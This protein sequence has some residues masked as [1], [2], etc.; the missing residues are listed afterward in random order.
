[1]ATLAMGRLRHFF[2]TFGFAA[3]AV[4]VLGLSACAGD[5]GRV[6]VDLDGHTWA[7]M[8][9][10]LGDSFEVTGRR[11]DFVMVDDPTVRSFRLDPSNPVTPSALEVLIS[12]AP[13]VAPLPDEQTVE[14]T[15]VS[16]HDGLV[17]EDWRPVDSRILL[18]PEDWIEFAESASARNSADSLFEATDHA[19][20]DLPWISESG[21]GGYL[22]RGSSQ[23]SRGTIA[24]PETPPDAPT[25][26]IQVYTR[27]DLGG[28]IAYHLVP[29]WVDSRTTVMRGSHTE[30]ATALLDKNAAS[31]DLNIIEAECR[32]EYGLLVADVVRVVPGSSEQMWSTVFDR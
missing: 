8:N 29:V 21:S 9:L 24:C 32:L 30:S 28:A 6:I 4:A 2:G 31:L 12:V 7:L 1:M 23:N 17:L 22:V 26:V 27:D 5:S 19:R 20:T 15:L 3:L 18:Y 11:G 10:G 14:A 13:G 25:H 16:N